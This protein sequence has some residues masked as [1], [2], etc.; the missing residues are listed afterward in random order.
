M[1]IPLSRLIFINAESLWNQLTLGNHLIWYQ[2]E[3]LLESKKTHKHQLIALDEEA[4][5][6][7]VP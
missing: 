1:T 4:A 3:R 7:V 2:Q 6:G 5:T